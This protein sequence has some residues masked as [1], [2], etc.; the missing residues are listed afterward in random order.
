MILQ[1]LHADAEAILKQTGQ[2]GAIPSMYVPKL[3]RWVV[4]IDS[5]GQ[6]PPMFT[7]LVGTNAKGKD[8]GIEHLL[9]SMKRASNIQPLLLADTPAYTLGLLFADDLKGK[10]EAKERAR[11]AQKFAAFRA[12]TAE[13]AR[14]TGNPDVLLIAQ[15]LETWNPDAPGAQV[16]PE[17]TGAHTVTFRVDNSSLYPVDDPAVRRFWAARGQAEVGEVTAGDL[18]M[19]CLLTGARGPVEEIMPVAVKGIPNGQPTGT[20]LVSANFAAAES[21]G[22]K[23]AQTSPISR[24]AGER[25]GKALN[26]LLA[27]EGNHRTLQNIV[28]VFWTAT[29][30]T[31]PLFILD[32]SPSIKE[33]QGLIDA[34]RRGVPW[35]SVPNNERF[36]IFGLSA[37]AARAVVRSALDITIE[38]LG[39]AQTAWFARLKIV[40]PNG[41]EWRPPSIKELMLAPYRDYKGIAPGTED[42]LVQAALS[43]NARLPES[44]LT[45]VVARCRVGTKKPN[46]ENA[47]HI[48]YERAALL[49]YILTPNGPPEVAERMSEL[50][51]NQTDAAYRC[52]RLLALLEHI[53]YQARG[54]SNAT[55]VDRFY[56][57]AST[58][59]RTVF[60]ALLRVANQG[61][62]PQVRRDR[63]YYA[64]QA[65][66]DELSEITAPLGQEFPNF[67]TV[68]Q[69]GQFA[70]GL[71][72][73]LARIRKDIAGRQDAKNQ[74]GHPTQEPGETPPT[75]PQTIKGDTE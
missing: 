54:K 74:A 42:A 29:S 31:P 40:G 51:T 3:L 41:Q 17:M 52:G 63:G 45:A 68:R 6:V 4:E 75:D 58:T 53:Q 28:Y 49:K 10:A 56:G 1:Q 9:P 67:F 15:F 61:H 8:I 71:Y 34:V 2:K 14:Q 33:V 65:L 5:T 23:R 19:Q 62:L 60:P 11:T 30:K 57:G 18:A 47:T 13:C 48:T 46:E 20:H 73:Q 24:D 22:L 50:D 70:L 55:L 36:H 69:Q 64:F 35:C 7:E 21:Y 59:P 32:I 27:S 44:L 26:A 37:N 38:E 25:F 72:F 66:R 12:L 39:K 43:P 16:P